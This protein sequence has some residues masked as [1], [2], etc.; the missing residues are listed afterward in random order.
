MSS[1]SF[2]PEYN[3]ISEIFGNKNSFYKMPFFQ[4]PYLWTTELAGK[5]FADIVES[6]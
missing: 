6:A 2:R 1:N 4:R 5:L 3:T